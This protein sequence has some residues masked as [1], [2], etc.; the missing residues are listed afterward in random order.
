MERGVSPA[1]RPDFGWGSC[2]GVRLVLV[3]HDPGPPCGD[4]LTAHLGAVRL[5]RLGAGLATLGFFVCVVSPL[6]WLA[7][8]GFLL[9]GLGTAT[10]FPLIISAAGHLP[11]AAAGRAI[12]LVSVFGYG[13]FLIGPPLIGVTAQHTGLSAA[14]LIAAMMTAVI[15][16]LA[17]SLNVADAELSVMVNSPTLATTAD[18][19]FSVEGTLETS[20]PMTG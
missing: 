12:A 4:R 16:V 3:G 14:L 11:G 2:P 5:L 6:P 18:P 17:P 1:T 13:G 8:L 19:R 20:T 10:M 15:A 7:A 9:V